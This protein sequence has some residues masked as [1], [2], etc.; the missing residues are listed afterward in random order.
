MLTAKGGLNIGLLLDEGGHL[1]NMNED[2]AETFNAF[3]AS[4]FNTDDRP[5]DPQSPVFEDCDWGNDKPPADSELV[6]DL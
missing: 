6:Q 5:W 3:F 1:T 2:K 4:V